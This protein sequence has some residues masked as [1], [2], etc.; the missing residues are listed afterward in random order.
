MITVAVAS[1][2]DWHAHLELVLGTEEYGHARVEPPSQEDW[3]TV[4]YAWDP[5]GVLIH[6]AQFPVGT[7]PA[8]TDPG[9]TG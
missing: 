8:G 2:A 4:T 9:T 6:F 5:S 7:E 1:A 3:A